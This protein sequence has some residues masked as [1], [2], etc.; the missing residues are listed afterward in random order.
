MIYSP[1]LKRIFKWVGYF[2]IGFIVFLCIGFTVA[3]VKR[4]E[5]KEGVIAL[6]NERVNGT[7]AVD[8]VNF[9]IVHQFP[10]FSISLQHVTLHDTVGR[11]PVLTADKIFLDIG[12]Y[13][14]FR[15]QIN[16]KKVSV[17]NG[18]VFIY[19]DMTGYSNSSVF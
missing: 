1:R 4:D 16:I 18:S 17:E 3:Y 14:L 8:K 10:V 2:T 11:V 15:N 13:A 19:K 6:L 12:F 5:I 7:F 9:T